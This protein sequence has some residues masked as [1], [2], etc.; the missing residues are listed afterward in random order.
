MKLSRNYSAGA[1]SILINCNHIP[2]HQVLFMNTHTLFSH[3]YAVGSTILWFHA[4]KLRK[5]YMVF[6]TD[7]ESGDPALG[8]I[9]ITAPTR[10]GDMPYV[11]SAIPFTDYKYEIHAK[12][13]SEIIGKKLHAPIVLFLNVVFKSQ[14][15]KMLKG[16]KLGALKFCEALIQNKK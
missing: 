6:I 12:S 15:M 9:G 14:D 1:K 16:L 3:S 4:L 2:S 13:I 5:G 11:S 8:N 10:L 7:H